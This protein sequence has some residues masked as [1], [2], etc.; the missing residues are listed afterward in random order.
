MRLKN[1]VAIITGA[2]NGIGLATAKRFVTE[3]A[4]V[5]IAD[6]RRDQIDA[7]VAECNA[8]GASGDT[9]A[10]VCLQLAA[11]RQVWLDGT[12]PLLI[13]YGYCT[14]L[15]AAQGQTCERVLIDADANSLTANRSSFY[16]AISRARQ[17]ARIYTDDREML[18]LAMS[19][20]LERESALEL[21]AEREEMVAGGL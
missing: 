16:V 19:R 4:H 7:A 9:A 10:G 5:I 13:D 11:G 3:G 17:T 20:E 1:K 2:A 21:V 8:L 6:L 14:T 12:K 15:Y 18:P